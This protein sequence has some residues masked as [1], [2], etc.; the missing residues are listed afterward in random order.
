MTNTSKKEEEEMQRRKPDWWRLEPAIT[1]PGPLGGMQVGARS[2]VTLHHVVE[3]TVEVSHNTD[4]AEDE[5]RLRME[6][7]LGDVV[8]EYDLVD[9]D[10]ETI[11]PIYEDQHAGQELLSRE[12]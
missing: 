1:E 9:S 10:I 5:A 3:T 6:H 2:R 7:K 11:K 8:D 4:R 12:F